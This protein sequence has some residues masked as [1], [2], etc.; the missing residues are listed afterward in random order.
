MEELFPMIDEGKAKLIIDR[1][2]PLA[3]GGKAHQHLA[4]RGA[5][6]KVILTP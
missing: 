4:S 5:H 6:G 1:V 3:E 2:L